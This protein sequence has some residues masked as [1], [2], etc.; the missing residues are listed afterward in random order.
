MLYILEQI[1][2]TN[3]IETPDGKLTDLHSNTPREQGLFLQEI[4]DLVKPKKSIEVGLAYGISTLFILEKHQQYKNS[5]KCHIVIEPFP[6]GGVAE[7]NIEKANFSKL[8]E[9]KYFKSYD[10]LPKLYF[11]NI[12]VQFAYVDT[13]KVFDTVLQ[14]FYFIDKMLDIGGVFVLDDCGGSWTG[15]QRVARFINTLPHYEVLKR[16]S[17]IERSFKGKLLEKVITFL[18]ELIPFKEKFYSGVNFKTDSELNINY[19]C[20]AF[21]K[22]GDDKR[23]W[24]FDR[25]I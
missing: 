22:I 11:E 4:F 8:V 20:I 21:Q 2:K 5:E 13:T 19:R 17:R 7:H 9:Y 24:D 1:F 14:D 3:K 23:N 12:R 15:V 25:K 10:V 18:I 6:W 16:H